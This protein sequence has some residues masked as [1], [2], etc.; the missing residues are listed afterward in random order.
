MAAAHEDFYSGRDNEFDLMQQEDFLIDSVD[1]QQLQEQ[2]QEQH[3]QQQEQR[4]PLS[5]GLDFSP[6]QSPRPNEKREDGALGAPIEASPASGPAFSGALFGT[7]SPMGAPSPIGAPS[8]MG[9]PSPMG[10][11][12]GTPQGPFVPL[13][14][15]EKGKEA[16]HQ[17]QELQQQQQ[18]LQRQLQE[19]I[20]RRQRE[21]EELRYE[22]QQIAAEEI[23]AFYEQRAKNLERRRAQLK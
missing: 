19:E 20:E 8:S 11:S 18:E 17:Q 13:T 3:Q 6:I 2:Q 15:D 23:K 22:Q 16:Q 21:E 1:N 10:T 12:M 7:P 9:A 5:N 4:E 14:P